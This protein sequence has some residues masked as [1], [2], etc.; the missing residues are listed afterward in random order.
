MCRSLAHLYH[1]YLHGEQGINEG[2]RQEQHPDAPQVL[3]KC[4][5]GRSTIWSCDLS[6]VDDDLESLYL[7]V[8]HPSLV[9]HVTSLAK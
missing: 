4:V 9:G 2:S 8:S 7:K 3:L 1:Y 5:S 6:D